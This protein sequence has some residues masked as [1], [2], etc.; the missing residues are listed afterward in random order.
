ML[1]YELLKLKERCIVRAIVRPKSSVSKQTDLDLSFMGFK[2]HDSRDRGHSE[3]SV[4]SKR[5]EVILRES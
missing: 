1:D 4:K 2:F 3:S 5:I